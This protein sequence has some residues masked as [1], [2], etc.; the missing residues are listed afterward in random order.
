MKCEIQWV[1]KESK[2]EP[3]PDLNEAVGYAVLLNSIDKRLIPIC[4][5]HLMKARIS[6]LSARTQWMFL[7]LEKPSVTWDFITHT[8]YEIPKE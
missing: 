4:E 2:W 7:P 6:D 1:C 3:T 5:H 8:V